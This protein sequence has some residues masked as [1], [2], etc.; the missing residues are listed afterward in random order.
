MAPRIKATKPLAIPTIILFRNGLRPR[1]PGHSSSPRR[2][3]SPLS[4]SSAS[5]PDKRPLRSPDAVLKE[6]L[7]E[8]RGTRVPLRLLDIVKDNKALHAGRCSIE[9]CDQRPCHG[10]CRAALGRHLIQCF[11]FTV[12]TDGFLLLHNW[13]LNAFEC[14]NRSLVLESTGYAP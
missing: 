4:L 1:G 14:Q 12:S 5:E 6:S 9:C 3:G 2:G 7:C 13:R 11:A 10:P 8:L